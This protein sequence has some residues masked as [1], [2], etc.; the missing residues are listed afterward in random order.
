MQNYKVGDFIELTTERMSFGPAAVGR[1]EAGMVVFVLGAAPQEKVRARITKMHKNYYDAEIVDILKKSTHRVEPKCSVFNECGG[2]QWQHIQYSDQVEFK[3][4]ILL[5]QIHKTTR[6]DLEKLRS[7][8]KT[9]PA[10]HPYGYRTRI[11]VRAEN[12]QI[13]FFKP[14]TRSLVDVEKCE[15]AHPKIQKKWATFKREEFEEL[16]NEFEK[17][18]IE[19]S[20]NNDGSISQAINREH[21]AHGFTQVNP[22]QNEIMQNIVR[23]LSLTSKNRLCLFDLYGGDGNLSKN[24]EKDFETIFTVDAFNQGVPSDQI[25]PDEKKHWIVHS[26]VDEFL[27]S[28]V[29]KKFGYSK[30]DAVIADPS[31]N[32]L[33]EDA[34]Y[35]SKLNAENVIIVSCEPSKLSRDLMPFLKAYEI[36]KIDLIDMFPQ[37]YHIESIVH[38]SKIK[39]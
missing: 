36:S 3:K 5:H 6:L 29:W 21:A 39:A 32:G 13:G 4:E 18:K 12:N 28:K 7:L 11:Q 16:Q 35:I 15:V 27:K 20:L 34:L 24:L 37:T 25:N 23:E 38:L 19:W 14:G 22:E 30:P 31:R 2:C 26:R 33:D 17:I 8:T 9:H 1:I 10:P